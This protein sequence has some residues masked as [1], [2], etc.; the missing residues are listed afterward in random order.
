MFSAAVFG[1]GWGEGDK[2]V[3][4]C[5]EAGGGSYFYLCTSNYKESR[6]P[7]WGETAVK[8]ERA[9]FTLPHWFSDFSHDCSRSHD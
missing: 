1:V 9:V 4:M 7:L 6:E 2:V 3:G 8:I 5:V